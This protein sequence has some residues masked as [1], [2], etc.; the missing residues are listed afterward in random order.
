MCL[1]TNSKQD[2]T[3]TAGARRKAFAEIRKRKLA[4][5][6]EISAYLSRIPR[7]MQVI[8]DG[9]VINRNVYIYELN[10]RDVFADIKAIID[11]W[12]ETAGDKPPTRWFLEAQVAEVVTRATAGEAARIN[13]LANI[14]GINDPYRMEQVLTRPEFRERIRRLSQRVYS[15]LKTF[16]TDAA[17]DLAFTMSKNMAAGKGIRAITSELSARFDVKQSDAERLARTELGH[18]HR[19]ARRDMTIDARDRLKLNAMEQYISALSPTSR[20]SHMDLHLKIMSP[21]DIAAFYADSA[22]SQGGEINCLCTSQTV[23]VTENGTVL[24]ARK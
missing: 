4:A 17:T 24:G 9:P 13:G 18:A 10:D 11:R 22:R 19:E 12:F 8:P 1:A 14:A 5:M 21:E 7:A 15:G 23:I 2:P 16:S 20:T 6:R 3:N